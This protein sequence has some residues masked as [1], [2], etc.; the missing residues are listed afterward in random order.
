MRYKTFSLDAVWAAD[1][2][3]MPGR[4][5]AICLFSANTCLFSSYAVW[6]D[7]V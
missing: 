4:Y 5:C 3:C 2:V 1:D 7:G 6:A